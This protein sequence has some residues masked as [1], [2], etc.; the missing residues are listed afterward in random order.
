ML[1]FILQGLR[2]S[3]PANFPYFHVEFGLSAGNVHVIDDESKFDRNLG[4]S[5]LIG[6]LKLPAEDVHQQKRPDSHSAQQQWALEFAKQ[7]DPYDW[8]KQLA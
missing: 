8:T 7:W 4:R 5:T 3:I 6:L 1:G 2:G